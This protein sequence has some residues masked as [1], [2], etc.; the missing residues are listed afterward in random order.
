MEVWAWP[1]YLQ[2][3]GKTRCYSPVTMNSIKSEE[4]SGSTDH[5]APAML[6]K[7]CEQKNTLIY[8]L[9]CVYC[10]YPAVI[11]GE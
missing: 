1:A 10:K 8:S 7:I 11:T 6:S 5:R 2:S 4:R 9:T 3:G